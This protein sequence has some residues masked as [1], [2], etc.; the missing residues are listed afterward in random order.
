M[1]HLILFRLNVLAF[2]LFSP[3]ISVIQKQSEELDTL[4]NLLYSFKKIRKLKKISKTNILGKPSR[5]RYHRAETGKSI[6]TVATLKEIAIN[7]N[8]STTELLTFANYDYEQ[9]DLKTMIENVLLGIDKEKS[10]EFIL[11]RYDERQTVLEN[12]QLVDQ[13]IP[14]IK[15][16]NLFQL[17]FKEYITIKVTYANLWNEIDMLTPQ[18]I[19]TT[20]KLLIYNDFY[21]ENDYNLARHIALYLDSDSLHQ[22]EKKMIPLQYPERRTSQ[23][24]KY[25][26]L[27]ITNLITLY[28]YK[29]EYQRALELSH[30]E[31]K[32]LNG[33][34]NYYFHLNHLFYKY[35]ILWLL[36]NDPAY[37]EKAHQLITF[38]FELGLNETA[39]AFLNTLNILNKT[40]DFCVDQQYQR[41][42]RKI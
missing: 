3:D 22:L 25:Y 5:L 8:M 33:M 1:K 15:E 7:L 42:S 21:T 20:F 32:S 38:V 17:E 18:E 10:K 39:S 30:L 40:P 29:M 9:Q 13:D 36:D 37:L 26:H 16:L 23:L 24:K 31:Y 6:L 11:K 28:L 19:T 27:L 2:S 41:P 12:H 34:E 4:E 35:L 14:I